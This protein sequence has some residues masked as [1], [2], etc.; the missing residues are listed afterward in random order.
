MFSYPP[1]LRSP[2]VET[3]RSR[4]D[5]NVKTG[6]RLLGL[7]A[8][9]L[10]LWSGCGAQKLTGA[11][12]PTGNDAAARM[13]GLGIDA[14][15]DLP[16]LGPPQTCGNG[17]LDPGEQCDDGNR[18]SG[19]GCTMFCQVESGWSCPAPGQPCQRAASATDGS[20]PTDGGGPISGRI[21]LPSSPTGFVDDLISGVIG[22]WFAFGDGVGPN[23]NASGTDAQ[24]SDCVAKGGFPPADC[25]QITTPTPGLP[26]APTDPATSEM[27]TSGTAAVV[28]NGTS[29]NAPDYGD[30]WGAGIGLDFNDP[31]GDAGTRGYLDLSQFKGIAFDFSAD[32]LPI[33]AM[34]VNFPFLGMHGADAPYW[35]GATM[36]ASPLLGTTASP[37]H[38]E[39]DWSDV[40]GPFYLTQQTP[41]VTP[42]DFDPTA[43][44]GIQFQVFTNASAPTPYSFCVSELALVPK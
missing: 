14:A 17:H 44:Q 39:I 36:S 34:R 2:L 1:I 3:E 20:A 22:S 13:G 10:V 32:I 24:D 7:A 26:F 18:M 42:P 11:G 41:P 31:G 40:R 6:R 35:M 5:S 9:S 21:Y 38:V 29:S 19:D 23:A 28:R 15:V 4:E 27:C 33:A 16:V 37:Q 25:S 8:V 30:L 43:V 12:T